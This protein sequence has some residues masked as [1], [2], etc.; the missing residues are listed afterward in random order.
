MAE[1][2]SEPDLSGTV[3]GS[4]PVV[5]EEEEIEEDPYGPDFQWDESE[6]SEDSE[7]ED[8]H[9]P[10]PS[11]FN[12]PEMDEVDPNPDTVTV[13]DPVPVPKMVPEIQIE[14]ESITSRLLA[15]IPAPKKD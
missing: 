12:Y 15:L 6:D 5:M 11:L 13:S 2:E 1:R 4:Q 8:F 10:R 14:R 3:A 9:S 7:G